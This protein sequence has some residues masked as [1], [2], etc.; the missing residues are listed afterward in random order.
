MTYLQK[1][2]DLYAMIAEGQM[3]DAFE[4]Y[5]AEDIIMVEP[6]SDPHEGKAANRQ[7]ERE[8]L[9]SVQEI[10]GAGVSAITSNEEEAVTM[11]ENWIDLTFRNGQRMK[12][13]QVCVQRWKAGQIVH[14][15]F[16]YNAPGA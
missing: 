2:Q 5:Y 15:R 6:A 14:E 7:R 12:M 10:H 1:A 13:E 16:Y 4:K 8:W 3:M 9:D 11:V